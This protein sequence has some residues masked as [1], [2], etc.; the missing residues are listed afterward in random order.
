LLIKRLHLGENHNEYAK[1]LFNLSNCL[2]KKG[3]LEESSILLEKCKFIDGQNFK[4]DR[5]EY[6]KRLEN[7]S[8]SIK[9]IEDY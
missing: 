9:R 3:D 2:N 4:N 1:T 7:I 5:I 6:A 8:N